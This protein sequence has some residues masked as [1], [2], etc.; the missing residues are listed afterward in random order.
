[1]IGDD[2]NEHGQGFEV[3]FLHCMS[4]EFI[5]QKNHCGAMVGV[6]LIRENAG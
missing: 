4:D 1:M 6:S 2:E 3:Q 5:F